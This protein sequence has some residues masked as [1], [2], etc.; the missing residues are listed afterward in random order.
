MKKYSLIFVVLSSL[1]IFVG[2]GK[3][4]LTTAPTASVTEGDMLNSLTGAETV[5]DG[6]NRA[7]YSYYSAHD[8]FG[9]KSIDY[10]LDCLG[11]DFYPTENGYGWF[12][13][14]YQWIEHRN[15]NGG[16]LEYVWSYYYDIINN[17]NLV[18]ANLEPM[19]FEATADKNKQMSLLAQAYTYR[20]YSLYYLVQLFSEG[21]NGI[22]VPT[23]P[24]P[25]ALARSSEDKV[26]TQIN[27]DLAKAVKLFD[28]G[29][30]KY[31]KVN[32]SQIDEAVTYA[33]MARVAL[34]RGEWKNAANYAASVIDNSGCVLT[35][36]YTYGWNKAN[37]EWLWGALLIDEQQTSYASFFSHMDP[38]FGGYCSLGNQHVMSEKLFNFLS[39]YD[40]RKVVNQ[41]D[42]YFAPYFNAYFGGK[43]RSSFKY[44][45]MGEWTN[46]YLYIKLG[47]MYLI[48]AEGFA[49]IGDNANAQIYINELNKKRYINSAYYTPITLTGTALIN[50]ILM[51]RRA[52]LWGDGQRFFDMKRLKESNV[53]RTDQPLCEQTYTIPAGDKRFT[54]LIPQQ[55][56]NSNPNIKQNSL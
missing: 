56:I 28:D 44:T 55:E 6:I 11:D 33:I 19:S 26:Y 49:R 52:E 54:F 34:T 30:A 31:E 41:P 16:N 37:E 42:V 24:N 25:G 3:E 12:V 51:Y 47:E 45:G 15:V 38:F 53:G 20:A 13:A 5:L 4:F 17:A 29:G 46:D 39:K 35:S 22:P 48:A 1:L 36:D 14:W 18:I 50:E 27:A 21:G 43:K 32:V 8:K 23:I 40:Q 2:C 10:A 7:T 9:Q